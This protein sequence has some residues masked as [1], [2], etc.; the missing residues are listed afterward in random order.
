MWIECVERGYRQAKSNPGG[1]IAEGILNDDI[2]LP[3][4]YLA[5]RSKAQKKHIGQPPK[6]ARPLRIAAPQEDPIRVDV[7]LIDVPLPLRAIWDQF[8]AAMREKVAKPFYEMHIR[9]LMPSLD[10]AGSVVFT[11]NRFQE[12]QF[13]RL[14]VLTSFAEELTRLMGRLVDV[15]FIVERKIR[16]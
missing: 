4:A 16:R 15:R 14:N 8:H 9:R 7:P 13:S 5:A 11:I 1:Y 10:E 2:D 3:A 12:D 6:P